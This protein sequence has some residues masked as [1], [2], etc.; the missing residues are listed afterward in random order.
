[1]LTGHHAGRTPA[2]TVS[3]FMA[4]MLAQ[5]L[6]NQQVMGMTYLYD[7]VVAFPAME[8]TDL[9]Q[10]SQ[11]QDARSVS[12]AAA[13]CQ[14]PPVTANTGRGKQQ[15]QHT[16]IHTFCKENLVLPALVEVLVPSI[17]LTARASPP[18][19]HAY[20]RPSVCPGVLPAICP[21]VCPS[22]HPSTC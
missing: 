14:V 9:Q 21:F 2:E 3:V 5:H 8:A 6:L 13:I 7:S 22:L 19:I 20:V 1:M 4:N 12:S 17:C 18:I 10:W 16:S 11:L 15:H